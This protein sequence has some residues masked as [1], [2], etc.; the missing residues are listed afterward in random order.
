MIWFSGSKYCFLYFRRE[1]YCIDFETIERNSCQ[2]NTKYAT[3]T[4]IANEEKRGWNDGE[5][6]WGWKL[7]DYRPLFF[8][9]LS[10]WNFRKDIYFSHRSPSFHN[11]FSRECCDHFFSTEGVFP[12]SAVKTFVWLPC[13]HRFGSGPHRAS[14]ALWTLSV[15]RPFEDVPLLINRLSCHGFRVCWFILVDNYCNKCRQTFC[16]F[17]RARVQTS[18]NC[19]ASK[20]PYCCFWVSIALLATVVFQSVRIALGIAF[21]VL[22]SCIIISTFCYI[23]IYHALRLR[24][25]PAQRQ[26]HQGQ[27]NGEGIQQSKAQYKET[28]STAVWVQ[29]T[30]LACYL[31]Y[32]LVGASKA[33]TGLNTPSLSLAL[34]LSTSL[35]LSNLTINPFLYCWRMRVLL[36]IQWRNLKVSS[37]STHILYQPLQILYNWTVC[38][39]GNLVLSTELIA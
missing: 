21:A 15:I 5:F 3:I 32:G 37:D 28:V 34:T 30:L 1:V 13:L 35:L 19:E 7:Y 38:C 9:H 24:L 10:G 36:F 27:P 6:N 23:K 2:S 39:E 17:T 14:F 18:C 25:S 22:L 16:S 4:W 33:T 31:P 8:M 29:M 12:S 11:C 26:G 20:S